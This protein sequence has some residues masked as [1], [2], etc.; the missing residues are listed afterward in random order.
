M[1]WGA[2]AVARVGG[3]EK[4]AAAA[5][6]TI[7]CPRAAR[8]TDARIDKLRDQRGRRPAPKKNA[9]THSLKAHFPSAEARWALPFMPSRT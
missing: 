4:I 3:G 2:A 8:Y 7:A 5:A 6:E 9:W 1:W